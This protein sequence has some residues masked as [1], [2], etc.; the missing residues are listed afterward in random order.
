MASKASILIIGAS[1]GL[2]LAMSEEF[3]SRG[4]RVL[5]TVRKS[6]DTKLHQL[7]D[8]FGEELGIETLDITETQQIANLRQRLRDS[9][10]DLLFVNAGI[11]TYAG[12]TIAEATTEGF[13]SLMVTNALGPLRVLQGFQDLVPDNG[14]IAVM[15]SGLA[16]I[17]ENID[18]VWDGYSASKAALNMLVR[19]FAS[20]HSEKRRAVI[21]MAPGWVRTE[22]GGREADLEVHESI[23][24]VVDIVT[25]QIG[26]PG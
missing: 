2:G 17:T 25:S 6:A 12:H 22:M 3:L 21:L 19:G 10:F 14:T 15:S 23:P 18:G 4:W 7:R 24:R 9:H 13:N 5:G 1:R 26:K 16:S 20:R 11:L 8:R